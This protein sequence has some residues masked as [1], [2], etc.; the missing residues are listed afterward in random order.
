M[1]IS[2]EIMFAE[3]NRY[4]I[5]NK[6]DIEKVYKKL[7]KDGKVPQIKESQITKEHKA[8]DLAFEVLLKME[9]GVNSYEDY[10]DAIAKAQKASFLCMN[11]L[12]VLN[13]LMVT[14]PD[15]KQMQRWM[16]KGIS[17]ANTIFDA[18]YEEENKGHYWGLNETRPYIRMLITQMDFLTEADKRKEAIELGKRIIYLNEND[19][20]GIRDELQMLYLIEKRYDDYIELT[21]KYPDDF[22]CGFYYNYALYLYLIEG[23]AHPDTKQAMVEA[24]EFNPVVLEFLTK[25]KVPSAAPIYRFKPKDETGATLYFNDSKK[26]WLSA[27]GVQKWLKTF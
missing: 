14:A 15:K 9:A 7:N 25:R 27:F 13:A 3:A 10:E 26:L 1:P 8:E 21:E 5:A 20:N 24:I 12:V 16:E 19:N 18:A 23:A 2:T 4:A 17:Y 6:M 11:N 22:S